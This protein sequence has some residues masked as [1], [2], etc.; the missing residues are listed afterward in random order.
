MHL[1]RMCASILKAPSIEEDYIEVDYGH[2]EECIDWLNSIWK[3]TMVVSKDAGLIIDYR[4]FRA[5][6]K[7]PGQ[8][9]IILWIAFKNGEAAL[10]KGVELEDVT[11]E[12]I[13][14]LHLG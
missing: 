6:P 8:P 5:Y 12:V 3:P 11:K 10:D 13:R 7:S 14:G 2:F 1:P 4:V 9:N